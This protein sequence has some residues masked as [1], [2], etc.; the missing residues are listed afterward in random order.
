[1]KSIQMT[2]DALS[3]LLSF[4]VIVLVKSHNNDGR[5]HRQKDYTGL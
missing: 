2:L 4:D 5:H 3:L 1:M